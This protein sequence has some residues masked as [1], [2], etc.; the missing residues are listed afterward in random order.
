MSVFRFR[1]E[2]T[3]DL[4][5]NREKH[6]TK[7]SEIRMDCGP[8]PV[9]RSS[10]RADA[11]PLAARPKCASPPTGIPN[12]EWRAA[13]AGLKPLAAARPLGAEPGMTGLLVPPR[14]S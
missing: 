5:K 10:S 7:G 13:A 9:A 8:T 4:K 3:C 12:F 1:F 14:C 6:Q 2:E 11:P